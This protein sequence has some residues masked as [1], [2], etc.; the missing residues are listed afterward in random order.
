AP[1]LRPGPRPPGLDPRDEDVVGGTQAH[2]GRVD[3]AGRL[4]IGAA[5]IRRGAL[6]LALWAA[7][8]AARAAFPAERATWVLEG[9][10]LRAGAGADDVEAAVGSLKKPF[11]AAAWARAHGDAP[12]PRFTC[13]GGPGCWLRSGHG[14]LGLSRA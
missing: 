13:A 1:L 14:V 8:V 2:G 10:R 4:R 3:R 5:L 9:A 6:I 11:V 7:A 12:T